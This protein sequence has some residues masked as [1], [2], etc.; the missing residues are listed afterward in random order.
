MSVI[1]SRIV[2]RIVEVSRVSTPTEV[3]LERLGLSTEPSSTTDEHPLVSAEVYYD[4]LERCGADDPALP[5]R[6]AEAIR[7]EDFGAFGLAIKTSRNV[8]DALERLARYILV[9]SDT[10]EYTLRDDAKGAV[11]VL[12]G[13]PSDDRRG[14]QLANECAL[15]AITSLLRQVAQGPVVP[16]AVSFRHPGPSE[17]TSHQAW[18]QG[19]LRFEA[20]IDGLHLDEA[21]LA[22]PTRLADDGLSAYLLAQLDDIHAQRAEAAVVQQVRRA[23]TDKLCSGLPTRNTIARH[24]GMS[25][26]TL[27]RRLA[28]HDC[29]FQEV[30]NQVRRETA[31]SLLRREALSLA[32]VAYLTG[33][34]DQSAFH[35]AFKS[36]TGQT[37]RSFQQGAHRAV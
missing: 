14:V 19:A 16:E 18:F 10:L 34:S 13:R 7:P 21:T 28:E 26:R 15:A 3:L 33:F 5:L 12:N 30:A 4:L 20:P 25:G 36:W 35:R 9:V 29:S 24:L 22:T 1:S 11:F 31:E 27:H 6:Y 37:P 23:I 32:E 8:R 2:R 17:V